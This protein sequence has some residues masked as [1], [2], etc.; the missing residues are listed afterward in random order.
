MQTHIALFTLITIILLTA[1]TPSEA[2][3]QVA[4]AQT[5]AE[6]TAFSTQTSYPT[7]TPLPTTTPQPTAT[8]TP[9][10]SPT[11][12]PIVVP[13]ITQ[14]P[15]QWSGTYS[16]LSG[17]GAKQRISL[18]IEKLN[19]TEFTGKMVWRGIDVGGAS[20]RHSFIKMNGEFITEF[21]DDE[22]EQARWN[23]HEDYR[24]GDINGS[25][26]KWTETEIIDGGANYTLNGWYYAHI[27]ESG[28]M[29]V[30]YFFND[31]EIVAD[32]AEIVLYKK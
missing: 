8:E 20:Y 11:I 18:L 30:V 7:Y 21:G 13:T 16:Y 3:I 2:S 19:G 23:N 15:Q 17:S 26:L 12:E 28:K 27:R 25:W 22:V 1:C 6:W 10:P 32:K 31:H 4:I 9:V 14:L 24:N 29:V 5:Q